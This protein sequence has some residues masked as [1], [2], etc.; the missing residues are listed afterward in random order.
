MVEIVADAFAVGC[1][2]AL[3]CLLLP[4]SGW[5]LA[6]RLRD[7]GLFRFVA[8]CLA[9]VTTMAAAELVVYAL[10]LPQAVAVALVAGGCAVSLRSV[11]AAI[12]RREFAWDALATWAGASAILVAATLHYAVHGLPG[13]YW[14]WY[15]HWLRSL[16]FLTQGPIATTLGPA[17]APY[18]MPARG[19]LFSGAAA[20]LLHLTGSVHYWVFQVFATTLNVLVCLPFALLLRTAGG[21]SRRTALL[22]AAAV[23]VLLPAYFWE[24]TYTWTKDL[25]AA[26]VLFGIH[27]YLA[28]FRKGSRGGMATS[29]AYLAPGFLCHYLVLPYAAMLGLHLLRVTPRRALPIRALSWAALAWAVPVAFWFGFMSSNFGVKRTLGANT[30]L[31]GYYDA[32]NYRGRPVP[33]PRVL[34]ANLCVDLLPR[35]FCRKLLLPQIP[36]SCSGV[37]VDGAGVVWSAEPCLAGFPWNCPFFRWNGIYAVLGYSGLLAVLLAL[38]VSARPWL[39]HFRGA[40]VAEDARFLLWVL[41]AGLFLNL[42]PIRWF[43]VRGSFGENLQAWFLVFS[44]IVVRGLTRL[45]RLPLAMLL[46]AMAAEYG[47]VDLK[48]IQVQSVIL[49]MPLHRLAI[50]GHPPLGVLLPIPVSGAR[51]QATADYY[52]NYLLKVGGGAVFFRDTHPDSF[53]AVSSIILALGLLSVAV[54]RWCA[55]DRRSTR[56]ATAP[57]PP[58]T[59]S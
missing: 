54:G 24:N 16:V 6:S 13:L 11:N 33:Q 36:T 15:E 59:S 55:A 30:T 39:R 45:P 48:I 57:S 41:T 25:T 34:A 19:P 47:S 5:W 8:A 52:Q 14:D 10:R 46:L 22:I 53:A 7:D 31:G 28:A 40:V 20:F 56:S 37:T 32:K 44:T 58:G 43:D 23:T 51:F 3:C 17:F 9:G 21:V 27:E 35:S 18:I 1:P 50:Q 12:R 38:A 29:L 4:L 26:F 42:L 49:P 2:I